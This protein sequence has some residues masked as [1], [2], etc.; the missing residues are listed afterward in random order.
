MPAGPAFG[1]QRGAGW[2][3]GAKRIFRKKGNIKKAFSSIGALIKGKTSK[4]KTAVKRK[5]GAAA[6]AAAT[7]VASVDKKKLAR[8]LAVKAGKQVAKEAI[9]TGASLAGMYVDHVLA[10]GEQ[11]TGQD[12]K[13]AAAV[14]GLQMVNSALKGKPLK[15]TVSGAMRGA[16]NQQMRKVNARKRASSTRRPPPT[17]SKRRRTNTVNARVGRM[18]AYLARERGQRKRRRRRVMRNVRG[19]HGRS[20]SGRRYGYGM[21]AK[22]RRRKKKKGGRKKKKKTKTRRRKTGGRKRRSTRRKRTSTRRTG[23]SMNVR[24]ATARKRQSLVNLFASM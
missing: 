23:R 21:G 13:E 6:T 3:G 18:E 5:A 17:A 22:K 12:A 10:G 8:K 24:K 20:Y 19:Y 9:G 15:G 14:A 11:V 7:K 4:A 1:V 16:A 2:R